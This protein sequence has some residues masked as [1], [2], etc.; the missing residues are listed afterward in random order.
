MTGSRTFARWIASAAL[1]AV[2]IFVVESAGAGSL[3]VAPVLIDQTTEQAA[4]LTLRDV[5]DRPVSVQLRVFRWSQENGEDKLTPTDDV[6]VS[7]P[8][9]TLQPRADYVVRVVRQVRRPASAEESY[10]LLVDELPDPAT[11]AAGGV[12]LLVRQ[13][14]PVFFSSPS[15]TAPNV[16]WR[17]AGSTLEGTNTGDRRM[18]VSEVS[19]VDEHGGRISFGPGLRGYVLGHS[20]VRW[21]LP[22][23]GGVGRLRGR[24]F[25][26]AK[27][28]GGAIRVPLDAARR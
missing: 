21:Q 26:T 19:I 9:T 15:R 4:A 22:Q 6:V 7:P 24:L 12:S 25:V 20:S 11:R 16:Q 5:G 3:Q 13:S 10:R 28:E 18:R 23:S 27:T 2:S 8:M 1:G 17:L 14:I